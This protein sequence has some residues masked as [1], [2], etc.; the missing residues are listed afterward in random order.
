[1][2]AL[3]RERDPELIHQRPLACHPVM[4]L[5]SRDSQPILVAAR[6]VSVNM[7]LS[8]GGNDPEEAIKKLRIFW[9]V[10]DGEVLNIN[11]RLRCVL[12]PSSLGIEYLDPTR[13]NNPFDW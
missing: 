8:E 3:I 1:L 2:I 4:D 10:C 12:P 11:F 6:N 9:P 13:E 7:L 5:I